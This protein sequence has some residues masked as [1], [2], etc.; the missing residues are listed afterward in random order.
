MAD[1]LREERVVSVFDQPLLP[2]AVDE[3][4]DIVYEVADE[5]CQVI[6]MLLNVVN[7]NTG[8]VPRHFTTLAVAVT[9][10]ALNVIGHKQRG[11]I[12]DRTQF[13]STFRAIDII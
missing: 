1:D 11:F 2:T 8:S 6:G 13:S 4:F 10:R 5:T 9:Q 12:R 7:I 3:R